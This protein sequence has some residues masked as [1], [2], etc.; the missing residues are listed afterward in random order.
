MP[1]PQLF[2]SSSCDTRRNHSEFRQIVAIA[3]KDVSRTLSREFWQQKYFLENLL[4]ARSPLATANFFGNFRK[5]IR[6]SI[7]ARETF[8]KSRDE[9]AR[10]SLCRK[11]GK[12]TDRTTHD[13]DAARA[14]VAALTMFRCRVSP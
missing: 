2:L 5:S 9:I 3:K 6:K 10:S 8:L 12:R 4:F 14:N 7:P 13:G 11:N 1:V